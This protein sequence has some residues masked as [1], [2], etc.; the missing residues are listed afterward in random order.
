[1]INIKFKLFQYYWVLLL[2][3]LIVISC[4]VFFLKTNMDIRI[5]LTLF[6]SLL[7]LLF[8]LQKQR[9]E[10]TKLFREKFLE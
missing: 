10:E 6:G 4:S 9:L 2:I 1:M 8:F 7:S 5:L 3:A